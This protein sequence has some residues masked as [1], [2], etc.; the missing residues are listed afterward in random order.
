MKPHG[1]CLVMRTVLDIGCGE[2]YGTARLARVAGRA[3]GV[4][5]DAATIGHAL[6]NH[7]STTCHYQVYDGIRLPFPD[8]TFDAAVTCQVIEHVSDDIGFAA[9]AA[10]VVRSAELSS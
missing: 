3:E 10:R 9:E 4:D 8:A 7:G 5:V 1:A 2:G 6:R